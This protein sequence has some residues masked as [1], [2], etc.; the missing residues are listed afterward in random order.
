MIRAIAA[1]LLACGASSLALSQSEPDLQAGQFIVPQNV[2]DVRV[3]GFKQVSA[4]RIPCSK[5]PS[6]IV[7]IE[8]MPRPSDSAPF[9]FVPSAGKLTIRF[10]GV[11]KAKGVDAGE[12]AWSGDSLVF[13]W[14]TFPESNF[15]GAVKAL[16]EWLASSAY[17]MVLQDGTS[18]TIAPKAVESSVKASADRLGLLTAHAEV[19]QINPPLTLS[20]EATAGGQWEARSAIGAPIVGPWCGTNWEIALR[21]SEC[22]VRESSDLADRLHQLRVRLKESKDLLKTL[23]PAQAKLEIAAQEGMEKELAE[24]EVKVKSLA[25]APVDGTLIVRVN[26][27]ASGREYAVIKVE[28]KR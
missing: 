11:A 13:S 8:P 7:S 4:A 15:A 9:V 10:P 26:S 25:R 18:L 28:I 20:V 24:L 17:T 22:V 1:T 12:F 2:F 19:G 23:T 6:P 21:G 14:R 16:R 27:A 3:D 5:T